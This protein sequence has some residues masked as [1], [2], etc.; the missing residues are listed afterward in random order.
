MEMLGEEFED[1]LVDLLES[2]E[3]L[4]VPPQHHVPLD[5]GI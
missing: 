3:P 2:I 4:I 5:S 1:V